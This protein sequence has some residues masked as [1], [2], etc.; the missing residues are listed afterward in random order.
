MSPFLPHLLSNFQTHYY[1]IK[2]LQI[3]FIFWRNNIIIHS[4]DIFYFLKNITNVN[5]KYEELIIRINLHLFLLALLLYQ[6][7]PLVEASH[8]CND[9]IGISQ[10]GKVKINTTTRVVSERKYSPKTVGHNNFHIVFIT[11]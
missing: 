6:R 10:K 8:V 7:S 4:Y 5:I 1:Y 11:V 9:D 3:Y 2:P